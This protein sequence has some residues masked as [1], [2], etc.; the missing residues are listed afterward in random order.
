LIEQQIAQYQLGGN[1]GVGEG[2]D[3]AN[4]D[5]ELL[6][7]LMKAKYLALQM[8]QLMVYLMKPHLV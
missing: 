6:I 5:D 1:V 4:T 2:A 3:D 8:V 7:E